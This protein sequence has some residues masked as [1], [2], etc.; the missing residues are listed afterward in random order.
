MRTPD[1]RGDGC[2]PPV[3]PGEVV[4][5]VAEGVGEVVADGDFW[6]GATVCADPSSPLASTRIPITTAATRT[7]SRAPPVF[8]DP[9]PSRPLPFGGGDRILAGAQISHPSRR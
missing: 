8:I 1:C 6:G 5:P 9:F 7:I 4:A 3:L 2:P